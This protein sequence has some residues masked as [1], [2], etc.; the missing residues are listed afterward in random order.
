MPAATGNEACTSRGRTHVVKEFGPSELQSSANSGHNQDSR[1][2]G[3][4]LALGKRH[5]VTLQSCKVLALHFRAHYRTEKMLA[6]VN[7][8]ALAQL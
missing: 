5:V 6:C 2:R 3:R 1:A 7:K 8:P 4:G